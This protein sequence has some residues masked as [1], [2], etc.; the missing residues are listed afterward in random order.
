M[1]NH[2]TLD[3]VKKT[4]GKSIM[5]DSS[6]VLPKNI[7]ESENS[8]TKSIKKSINKSINKSNNKQKTKTQNKT[9]D[10]NDEE[11][12]IINNNHNIIVKKKEEDLSKPPVYNGTEPHHIFMR[13]FDRY[14]QYMKHKETH[15]MILRF[16]N[17]LFEDEYKSLREIT[18]ITLD[19][20]PSCKRF[21]D[22]YDGNDEYKDNF[23]LKSPN[24]V[25]PE[26]LLDRIMSKIGFSFVLNDKSKGKH[27][28]ST[29]S[30]YPSRIK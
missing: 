10:N 14:V 15:T 22:V 19:K 26:I 3:K 11:E 17:E 23:K 16:M 13:K 30:I 4:L 9:I 2:R 25:S 21:M 18:N 28:G 8:I 20:I 5:T 29:Y 24:G 7:F 12:L 1:S 27:S 6:L